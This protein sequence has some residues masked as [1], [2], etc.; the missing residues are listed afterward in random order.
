[1]EKL[2]RRVLLNKEVIIF[3]LDGT[4]IDT[5]NIWNKIDKK[6][7][8]K[9]NIKNL[10]L[11]DIQNIRDNYL[12]CNTGGDIYLNYIKHLVKKYN[13]NVDA[14]TFYKDRN[15]IKNK[16]LNKAKIKPYVLKTLKELKRKQY[17]LVLAT[18]SSNN[19]IEIYKT[20][21]NIRN[22]FDYFD[23][24]ITSNDVKNKKPNP[25][26]YEL[27]LKKLRL[28][29][30]KF[31]VFEDSYMGLLCAKNIKIEKVFINNKYSKRD[32]NIINRITEYKLDN[33]KELYKLINKI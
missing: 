16:L 33:Y 17:I 27:I 19:E 12:F 9:Y 28:P 23:L 30:K 26:I 4:L 15:I 1:M 5:I 20:N 10:K 11:N 25:E 2:N 21:K 31:L 7:L 6:T 18:S 22:I 32:Y 8:E 24:I 13:L 14:E 3:D 29:K